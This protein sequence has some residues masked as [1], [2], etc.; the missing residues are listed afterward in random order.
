MTD[1]LLIGG[2]VSLTT[3]DYP[4]YIASVIFLQ[5]CP[6]RCIYC[7]NPHLQTMAPTESL[8]W[9]DVL[10]LLNTR[11]NFVEAVVFSGGE[12]LVQGN[13]LFS[14]IND[15]KN[16]GYKIGIHTAGAYPDKLA[17]I[18]PLLDWI[19]F[20]IKHEF[21]DYAL[22]TNIEGSGE[23][24][25]ESLKMVI[26]SGVQF[27][28]RMTLHESIPQESIVKTLKELASMGVKTVALQK[29]R[30]KNENIIEHPIFSDKLL[31]ENISKCFD[32]F[33]I[34]G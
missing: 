4:G 20:D 31:I 3:V 32:N 16:I 29:C 17:K 21:K 11:K 13:A 10:R 5:G 24:A 25:L 22:I 30:D 1:Q 14:A 28:V 26:A 7:H 19:G 33:Y 18:L 15:V 12:P 9:E 8:P 27:E 23:L 34:R 6:W 2:I